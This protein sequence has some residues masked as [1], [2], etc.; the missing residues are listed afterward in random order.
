[1]ANE[2]T[3]DDRVFQELRRKLGKLAETSH[4]RV[5]VL[6]ADTH[7]DDGVGM[8]ELAAIHEFGSPAAGIPERSFI[9]AALQSR[10]DDLIK[11]LT[12]LARAILADQMEPAEALEILGL[13]AATAVKMY[14][15]SRHVR[16]QLSESEAGQRT[17]ARKGSDLTLV[18]DAL[19]LNAITWQA[20][21]GE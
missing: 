14:I 3:L 1:M 20:G 19:L 5:G 13:W 7:G 2:V 4:V 16:P 6:S 9:R 10:R 18:D 21:G 15:T 17:I 8:A 12:R 11:L